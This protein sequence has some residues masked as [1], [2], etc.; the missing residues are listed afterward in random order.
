MRPDELFIGGVWCEPTTAPRIDVIAP[1]TEEPIAQVAAAGPGD[2]DA[3]VAAART[4]FDGGPWPRLDPAERIGAVRRLAAAYG[5]RR[6]QMAEIITSEIGAPISFAQRAQVALPWTMMTAFCDLAEAYPFHEERPGR[7]GAAVHIRREPV[8]VVAA[9]VPWNMPQFLIVTKLVPALLA[10]C[11]VILKPAPE[12]PLNALLLAEMI[13]ESDLPPGVVSV[14]PGDG[15]AGEYLVKHAGVDKVSFTGSTTAGK[16]V[17]AACAPDLKRVSLELGGKSAAIVLDD[18]DPATVAS[19]VR[20]ASLSNSGQICN[21]LTRILVPAA[22]ADEFTDALA[23]EMAALVVGD[24]TDSATQVGP[25]VAQRQQQRVRGY[26]A[27]GCAEGARLVTGGAQMPDGVEKGWYVRPTLFADAK[28]DMRIAREEIF[29]PVLT[30]IPFADEQ[31]AVAI[32]NDS[33][34]GLAGSVFTE[35]LER[36]LGV[37]A[38][39]RTGTFGVNQGY[40]MDPFAPFGGVKGSGYGRELGREGIDGYTDTK[41]ISVAAKQDPAT[42]A[43]GKGA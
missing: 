23:A 32:A 36:G 28:N 33:D 43:Q 8:G 40:T 20:S 42:A 22:R 11:V 35:D 2:V 34:Y 17:A 24:P 37:A 10:G 13:A 19:G 29:G 21:A 25:L 12:S 3:A 7:Y 16:A 30:V 26:I 15:S 6:S 9:I 14:L 18:A 41:S 38:R 31:E 39:I 4:A 1:H 27:T 5:E